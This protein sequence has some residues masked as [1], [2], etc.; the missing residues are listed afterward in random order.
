MGKQS[1]LDGIVFRPKVRQY[2]KTK[3]CS[4]RPCIKSCFSGSEF[5][6]F[7]SIDFVLNY[8]YALYEFLIPQEYQVSAHEYFKKSRRVQFNLDRKYML[9][10]HPNGKLF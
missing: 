5:C 3:K 7:H 2:E 8:H 6:S 10:I 4:W 1:T 9:K